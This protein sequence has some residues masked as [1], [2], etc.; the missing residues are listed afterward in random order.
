MELPFSLQGENFSILPRYTPK[1]YHYTLYRVV[2]YRGDIEILAGGYRSNHRRPRI[3]S[4]PTFR[5]RR[6][7]Q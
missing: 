1:S 2:S 6:N 5:F 4:R 7:A 3:A